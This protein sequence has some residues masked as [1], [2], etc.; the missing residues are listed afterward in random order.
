MGGIN[1]IVC[2]S[3][4]MPSYNSP[5]DRFALNIVQ[6][7]RGT[8]RLFFDWVEMCFD[9]VE[10]CFDWVEMCFDWIDFIE[11]AQFPG[12]SGFQSYGFF[13]KIL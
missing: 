4:C 5:F 8:K 12:K 1:Q 2:L 3:V 9:W 10:M 7:P 6:G 11:K 13:S